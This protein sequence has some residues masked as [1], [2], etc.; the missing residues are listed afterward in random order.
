MTDLQKWLTEHGC[1]KVAKALGLSYPA[2]RKWKGG[3]CVPSDKNILAVM[4]LSGMTRKQ[5]R[6]Q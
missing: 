4:K 1:Y 6:G 5:V 3:K 2:V